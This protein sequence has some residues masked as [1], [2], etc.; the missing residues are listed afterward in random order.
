MLAY[1]VA[2]WIANTPNQQNV[3]DKFIVDRNM[4]RTSDNRSYQ[5]LNG[6]GQGLFLPAANYLVLPLWICISRFSQWSQGRIAAGSDSPFWVGSKRKW[7]HLGFQ[8][9]YV[10]IE[11]YSIRISFIFC[12]TLL[13]FERCTHQA[14]DGEPSPNIPDLSQK[15]HRQLAAKLQLKCQGT[16]RFA[17]FAFFVVF[18]QK[19]CSEAPAP[20]LAV[21]HS[22]SLGL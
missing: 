9:A 2:L 17:C 11:I 12:D 4:M 5:A 1:T 20:C 3:V 6:S 21:R 8:V 10:C 19:C 13:R 15:L 18:Y 14:G 7:R 22:G 16:L